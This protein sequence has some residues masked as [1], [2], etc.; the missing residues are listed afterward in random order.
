MPLRY[1][2][3]PGLLHDNPHNST[4]ELYP[5]SHWAKHTQSRSV[6]ARYLFLFG[7]LLYTTSPS[8]KVLALSA[9]EAE[10][11]ASA[12]VTNDAVTF[13]C[14]R[15]GVGSDVDIRLHLAMEKFAAR[16]FPCRGGVGRS[17]GIVWNH[18]KIKEGCM[19]GGIVSTKQN[20]S[21]LGTKRLPRDRMGYLMYLLKKYAM[22]E[23][24]FAGASFA[25]KM[26][27]QQV[28]KVGITFFQSYGF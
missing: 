1:I 23:S 14:L 19:T 8:Q 22:A 15:F 10:I 16:S 13:H 21:D 12:P 17:L 25:D 26:E 3:I 4:L 24:Q 18:M 9:A 6:S 20:V 28:L 5:D 2:A 7:C 11:Y 27:D